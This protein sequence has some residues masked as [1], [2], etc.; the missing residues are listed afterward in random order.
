MLAID[1]GEAEAADLI[2][3]TVGS[4]DV[5]E[6]YPESEAEAVSELEVD[7]SEPQKPPKTPK[8][9]ICAVTGKEVPK[10]KAIPLYALRPS[11]AERIRIDFPDIPANAPISLDAVGFYRSKVVEELMLH[12]RGELSELDRQVAES[13]SD[14]ESIVENIEEEFEEKRSFGEKLSD[15]MA[16]FGGSWSFLLTF[17]AILLIWISFNIAL[18]DRTAF[19]PYPFILLNLVLSCIAAIQAPIIMMSQKRQETK[20]RLR[21]MNDYKVNLKAELEIRHL[22]EKID[23]LLSRQWQRLAEMQQLQIEQMQGKRLKKLHRSLP[24]T[25]AEAVVENG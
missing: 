12:D 19:D 13:M 2:E 7:F 14:H 9:T 24:A 16:E 18:G 10:K 4:D 11:L 6:T 15:H 8:K 22:H 17:A 3:E 23:Y 21:A 5:G 25:P 20:D 1:L